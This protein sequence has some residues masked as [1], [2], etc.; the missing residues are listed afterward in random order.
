[1]QP[2]LLLKDLTDRLNT[3]ELLEL[4]ILVGTSLN[5]KLDEITAELEKEHTRNIT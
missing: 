3:S 2:E 4:A 1:M 5:R